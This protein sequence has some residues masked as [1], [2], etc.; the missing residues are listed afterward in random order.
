MTPNPDPQTPHLPALATQIPAFTPVPRKRMRRGGW[1]ADRQRAF[2][3]AL[4]DTGSVRAA[5]RRLGVGEHHIYQLRRHPEAES[6]R[7]AWEAALDIGIAKIEDVAMDRALN[8]VEEPVYHGGELVGTR[9][10]HNDRLLMFMLKNRAPDRFA[11]G[12]GRRNDA[13]DLMKQKR[14]EKRLET[15]MRTEIRRELEAERE[16]A[17]P[18]QEEI[19]ASLDRKIESVRRSVEQRKQREWEALSDDTREAWERFEA[20]KARDLNKQR[21]LKG[22]DSASE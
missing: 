6:F 20:L 22:S 15:K 21:L 5:C 16:A 9:R 19:R 14:R 1:S 17:A 8:G 3:E 12:R 18:T 10:V 13:I 4:A 7:K 2:I 11:E